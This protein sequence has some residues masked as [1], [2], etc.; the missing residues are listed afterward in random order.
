MFSFHYLK[1]NGTILRK[2][3]IQIHNYSLIQH[4]L[5]EYLLENARYYLLKYLLQTKC[6][7]YYEE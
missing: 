2:N 1:V 3:I 7:G 5:T 4:A 6:G